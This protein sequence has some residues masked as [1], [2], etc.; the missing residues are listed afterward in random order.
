MKQISELKSEDKRC[1]IL[2]ESKIKNKSNACSEVFKP[3]QYSWT[4]NYK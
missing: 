4:N 1:I 3:K 2:S